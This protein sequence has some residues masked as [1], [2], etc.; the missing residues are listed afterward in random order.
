MRGNLTSPVSDGRET[1]SIPACAGEPAADSL[2]VKYEKVYPRVCGGTST[3]GGHGAATAGLSPRV[4][5]NRRQ[6]A[7]RDVRY[8]S[9]PACAGEP[10][11]VITQRDPGRVYPRVCGG[12]RQPQQSCRSN[13]GLSP[14]V[15]G[16][17]AGAYHPAVDGGSI[18]ACAGEPRRGCCRC[19]AAWVYPRVCGGTQLVNP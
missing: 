6:F 11:Q 1:G 18:P 7:R 12:T 15:R 14:R 13:S 16:N 19:R 8:R 2:N 17:P 9:I 3:T 10:Q 5:G 4:R